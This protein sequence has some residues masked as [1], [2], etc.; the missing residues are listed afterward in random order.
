MT[1]RSSLE[2]RVAGLGNFFGEKVVK[3]LSPLASA[4]WCC[5]RSIGAAAAEGTRQA[6]YLDMGIFSP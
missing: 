5:V 6:Y 4:A 3:D 1:N 2:D